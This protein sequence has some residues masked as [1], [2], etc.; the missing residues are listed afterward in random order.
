MPSRYWF[1]YISTSI[2][3]LMW[4]IKTHEAIKSIFMCFIFMLSLV[5]LQRLLSYLSFVSRSFDWTE[6][7]L[8]FPTY[9]I[10][11]EYIV[12]QFRILRGLT[13]C[14]ILVYLFCQL[15]LHRNQPK[16]AIKLICPL[17]SRTYRCLK[18][19]ILKSLS[20]II[21]IDTLLE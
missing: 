6:H 1:S 16:R 17:R 21:D 14:Q 8:L 18:S 2:L 10:F 11:I 7:A 15:I 3:L 13:T 4:Y 20:S 12:L 19:I 9:I 5:T